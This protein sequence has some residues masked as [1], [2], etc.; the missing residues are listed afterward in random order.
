MIADSHAHV[1]MEDF[2]A[3]RNEVLT[4]ARD[5]GVGLIVEVGYDLESSLRV[6]EFVRTH[7]GVVGAVGVH[8]HD[9]SGWSQEVSDRIE[10]IAQDDAIVALGEMGLDYYRNLSSR[11]EQLKA[12]SEQVGLARKLGLPI[13]IHERNAFEDTFKTL[14]NTKAYELPAVVMHCFSGD[15]HQAR[16]CLDKGYYISISGTVTF[17]NSKDL[18]QVARL[19]PADRLLL[20]TDSPYLAPSPYRGKRNEPSY[21][22]RVL[23]HVA[24]LRSTSAEALAGTTWENTRRV[25]RIKGVEQGRSRGQG[26]RERKD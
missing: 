9:A 13:I 25:F 26:G 2:N 24:R 19:V 16:R 5:A 15:W 4:R 23:Q 6:L 14:M 21:V 7:E 10:K 20:E 1:S 11:E 18:E 12:F 3:D 17:R 22:K 8:P